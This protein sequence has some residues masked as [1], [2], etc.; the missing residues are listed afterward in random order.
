[1]RFWRKFGLLTA[2]ALAFCLSAFGQESQSL[3]DA[4]RQARLQKQQREAQEKTA[5]G[6]DS[7]PKDATAQPSAPADKP[8]KKVVTNDDIPEHVGSTLTY[9]TTPNNSN[10]NYVR[11]NYHPASPA[12]QM[13]AGILAQKNYLASVRREID[14]LAQALEHPETC[15][16]DC[17]QRDQRL[18]Y[19]EA[20]LDSLK[21]QVDQLQKQL[22]DIQEAARKKGYGSSVYDP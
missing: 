3:G 13:R 11:P 5:Q 22:E 4:A 2:I 12:D 6:K 8:A 7:E 14:S 21:A 1:M 20:R 9:S 19:K 17:R 10:P 15:V 16:A 18:R